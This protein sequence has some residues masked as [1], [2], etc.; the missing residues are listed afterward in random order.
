MDYNITLLNINEIRSELS[1]NPEPKEVTEIRENILN[2]FSKLRFEEVEHRYFL[3]K[4]DGTTLELDSVSHTCH[5]FQEHVDWDS[6]RKNKAKK[7][8]VTP[9]HLELCWKI[10]N[11]RSTTNGTMTHNYG[12]AYFRLLLND[13]EEVERLCYHQ[14]EDGFLLPYGGKEEAISKYMFDLYHNQKCKIYPILPETRVYMGVNPKYDVKQPFAG[15]F[16]MLYAVKTNDGKYKLLIHDY[17]TNKELESDYNRNVSNKTLLY[18]FTDLFDEP[19]SLYTLQL[20]CYQ[21]ALMQLGYE[22][23]DR[24]LIWLKDDGT[25]DKIFLPDITDKILKAL[26]M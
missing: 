7:V 19:K 11:L 1:R 18:P 12:E 25:Y 24:R 17:K 22:I 15:T 9:E 2:T 3:D 5:K 6:I 8:G 4:E 20:S 21:L 14:Y 16:D 23:I 13:E 10:N 26:N